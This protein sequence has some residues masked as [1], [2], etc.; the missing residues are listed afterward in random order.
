MDIR[1]LRGVIYAEL[2]LRI[3]L[4]FCLFVSPRHHHRSFC[5]FVIGVDHHPIGFQKVRRQIPVVAGYLFR[6]SIRDLLSF[7]R[8]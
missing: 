8:P 4:D 7:K 2:V 3:N 5:S 6:F 1:D